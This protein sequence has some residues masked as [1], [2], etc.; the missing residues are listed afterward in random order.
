MAKPARRVFKNPDQKGI[1]FL[2][3]ASENYL[4]SR[5]L[6]Q[7]N[8]LY[9]A[10]VLAHEALEKVMKALLCINNPLLPLGNEH[11]LNALRIFIESEFKLDLS[12]HADALKYYQDCYNYRYPD[13]MPPE[14]FSTGTQW[15]VYL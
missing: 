1:T 7:S 4:S 2:N 10:G 6:Y 8:Q 14:S 13:N 15:Y 5:I 9:D 3:R 11:D 12:D